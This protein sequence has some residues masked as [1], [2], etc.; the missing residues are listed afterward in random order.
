M[1]VVRHPRLCNPP[2]SADDASP[3]VRRLTA[4]TSLTV[5]CP[6]PDDP[7]FLMAAVRE[8]NVIGDPAFDAQIVARCWEHGV[9]RSL[10][11]DL[12]SDRFAGLVAMQLA[13][14]L[15]SQ[16]GARW[17]LY[18]KRLPGKVVDAPVKRGVVRASQ[19]GQQPWH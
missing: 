19:A 8:A 3:A 15:R 17:P 18:W 12:G 2:H 9:A 4:S 16:L 10:T 14:G 13:D 6:G 11:E 1:R 5:P 7:A